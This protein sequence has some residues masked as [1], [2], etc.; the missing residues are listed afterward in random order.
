MDEMRN[1]SFKERTNYVEGLALEYNKA[2]VAIENEKGA[3][4]L[5]SLREDVAIYKISDDKLL[6]YKNLKKL[7]DSILE[8]LDRLERTIL[9]NDFFCKSG[10]SWWE[11]AYS[12]ST[13]YRL[14]KKAIYSFLK[15]FMI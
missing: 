4:Y 3:K 2:L 11:H 6:M 8:K 1:W 5:E 13:Y 7:I 9:Y 10:Y 14:R 12:K 15:Y